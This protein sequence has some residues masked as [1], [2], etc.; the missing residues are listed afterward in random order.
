MK[1]F[2]LEI[3]TPERI[4]FKGNSYSL[5]VPAYKGYLGVMAGHAP[6][7]SALGQGKIIVRQE[8]NDIAFTVNGGF[9]E[10]TPAKTTILADRIENAA[11][12]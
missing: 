2:E 3:I 4:V 12:N 11:T 7:I 1:S 9:M 6:F 10:T 5:V 8:G